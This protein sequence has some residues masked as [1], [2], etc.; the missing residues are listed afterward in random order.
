MV[1][2]QYLADAVLHAL[3]NVL[4]YKFEKHLLVETSRSSIR[5]FTNIFQGN[6][7]VILLFSNIAQ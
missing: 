4:K 3:M 2:G 7:S 1:Y 5:T 6:G